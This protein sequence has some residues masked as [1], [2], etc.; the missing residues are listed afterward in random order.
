PL[1]PTLVAH[2]RDLRVFIAP[3]L[4]KTS[5]SRNTG[6]AFRGGVPMV[7]ASDGGD[8]QHELELMVEAGVPPL[9][10]IVAGTRNAAAAIG[11]LTQLGTIEVSKNA[12]LLLVSAN[13]G[14]D[15]RNLRQVALRIL[16][17]A[18]SR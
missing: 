7:L 2:L 11:R 18:V 1:D 14:E 13:P 9:D 12:N 6:E 8:L 15:V 5:A 10:A 3:V 17:E 16:G 4:T